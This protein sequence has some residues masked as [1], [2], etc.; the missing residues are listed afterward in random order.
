[1]RSTRLITALLAVLV[2]L[3]ATLSTGSAANAADTA[4]KARPAHKIP[5][6]KAGEYGNTG[7]FYVKG[8]VIT[9]KNRPVK[10]QKKNC[11]SCGWKPF[12]QQRTTSRGRFQIGFDGK[13]GNCFRIYVPATA[14]YRAT[15]RVAGCIVRGS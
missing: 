9:Y 14:K 13:I 6:F 15:Y 7:K 12:K 3:G 1:M 10:L 4:A 2:V 11:K 5:E 8:Q